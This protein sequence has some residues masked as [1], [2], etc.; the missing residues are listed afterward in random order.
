MLFFPAIDLMGGEVVRLQRGEAERKTVYSSDP[1]AVAR[2]WEARGGDW[3]H[4]VDLD[5]AF[6]GTARNL[7][8]VRAI[9]QAVGVPCQL[10]GGIRTREA[11]E[12]AFEAGVKRVVVGTRALESIDF[13]AELSQ[14]FGSDRVAVG[15]DARDGKVAVKGWTETSKMSALELARMA[16]EAGAGVIIYTDISTD[17]MLTGPDFRGL[18]AMLGAVGCRIIAS[19]GVSGPE[20]LCVLSRM[21]GL[22]GAIIGRALYEGKIEGNLR[23]ILSEA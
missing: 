16:E 15:I 1:A 13:V 5:A 7:E 23:A 20:D 4:V 9:T 21:E 10:G 14:E 2:E 17:G 12:A 6:Q 19:G 11:A 8:S 18:E 3:I 22:Y